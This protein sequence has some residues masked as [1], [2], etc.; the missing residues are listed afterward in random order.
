MRAIAAILIDGKA[1]AAEIRQGLARRV[2]K[3]S[4]YRYATPGLAVILIGDD[5]ASQ[6][7]VRNKEKAAAQVGIH[8]ALY[9]LPASVSQEQVLA[10]VRE[11]NADANIHGI[12]VQ[13]PVP[14]HL[15]FEAIVA[16]IDPAKDV[17]GF[18]PVNLGRLLR[19]QPCSVACTA[20]GVMAML[21][22]YGI[23]PAGKHAV[24][25]GRSTVVGKPTALLLLEADATVT[26]CH[27]YTEDLGYFTRQADILVVA[28]GKPGLITADMVKPGAAVI[29]VGITR[30]DGNVVGDVDF[31]AV[32]E[33]AGWL[34]PVPGG[35]GPMTV[36]MLMENTVEAAERHYHYAPAG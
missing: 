32:R 2:A 13:A 23:D 14:R 29:D 28:V 16:A 27:R 17:D 18:H 9:H 26:V 11:L 19:G 4:E 36:A 10:T 20:K 1:L 30:V 34:T 6:I 24:V 7:Y 21:R 3:L 31:A 35:V 33:V 22:R 25:V 5:P 12:L 8:S 15:S